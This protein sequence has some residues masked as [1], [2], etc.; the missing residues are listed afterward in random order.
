MVRERDPTDEDAMAVPE[1]SAEGVRVVAAKAP[2]RPEGAESGDSVL[3]CG[4]DEG[5]GAI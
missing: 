4:G 1:D 3:M 5:G 2:G